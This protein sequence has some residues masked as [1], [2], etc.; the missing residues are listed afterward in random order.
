MKVEKIG[1]VPGNILGMMADC[2]HKI[3]HGKIT[4]AEFGLFLKRKNPFRKND[5]DNNISSWKDF[6][7]KFFGIAPDFSNI[8]IPE[9]QPGF[10][11]LIIVAQGLT[12]NQVYGKC[13]ENFP[14]SRYADDLDK[15]I[16]QKNDRDPGK[17]S[18]AIWVRDRIEADEELQ[19]LSADVLKQKNI[20]GITLL[21]R[22][23]YELKYWIETEK[24]LDIQNWTLCAGSRDSGGGVPSAGWLGSKFEVSWCHSRSA[25]PY[26]RAR[27]AVS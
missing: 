20:P 7:Q 21:E 9:K 4:P 3:Q 11:R 16:I 2:C 25:D 15:A 5:I 23:L 14:C 8:K 18:Y 12:L 22:L 24:H 10:D 1:E 13:T 26:L 17:G 6:Y 27:A 19:N